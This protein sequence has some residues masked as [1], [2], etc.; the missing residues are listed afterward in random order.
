MIRGLTPG[1]AFVADLNLP[2]LSKRRPVSTVIHAT[3]YANHGRAQD[4]L[5]G[6]VDSYGYLKD[7]GVP[8]PNG[9]SESIPSFVSL[10]DLEEWYAHRGIPGRTAQM[11][12]SRFANT[13]LRPSA[14]LTVN[15]SSQGTQ[16]A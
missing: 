6:W 3:N 14:F 9:S 5:C 16:H 13:P 12:L 4:D 8:L 10:V 11:A 15:Q 2:I 1:R 7:K